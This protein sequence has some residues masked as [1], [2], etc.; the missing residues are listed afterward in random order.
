MNCFSNGIH[1]S[2]IFFIL[3]IFYIDELSNAFHQWIF[4]DVWQKLRMALPFLGRSL[5]VSTRNIESHQLTT[6][7]CESSWFSSRTR[8]LGLYLI[9]L[10]SC[11]IFCGKLIVENVCVGQEPCCTVPVGWLSMLIMI[12]LMMMMIMMMKC[13]FLGSTCCS[14][15]HHLQTRVRF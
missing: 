1:L 14:A 4:W 11:E 3:F 9:S 7:D 2:C 15:G 12:L 10:N 13:L 8:K 5:D 6:Y